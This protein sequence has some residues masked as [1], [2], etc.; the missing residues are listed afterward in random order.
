MLLF[1]VKYSRPDIANSVKELLKA[2]N[3]ATENHVKMLLRVMRYVLTSRNKGL[4]Y[5]I[6]KE[7]ENRWV[8]WGYCDSD[9]A[10]DRNDHRS[11]TR[12]C[13]Y[14]MGCLIAWKSRAQKNVTLLSSE[15]DNILLYSKYAVK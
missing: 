14:F 9:W 3:G 1:L 12:Y 4:H 7:K 13:V 8:R 15:V 2:N 6:P 5:K 10:G 11:I